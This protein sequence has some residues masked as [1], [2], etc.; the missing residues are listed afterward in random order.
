MR[1]YV[2]SVLVTAHDIA[3]D[4]WRAELAMVA[5][6]PEFKGHVTAQ[7]QHD[8]SAVADSLR[9]LTCRFCGLCGH[10]ASYCPIN[11]QMARKCASNKILHD[12]WATWRAARKSYIVLRSKMNQAQLQVDLAMKS[13]SI[14]SF[15]SSA[16]PLDG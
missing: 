3:I 1:N 6:T 11:A 8:L 10:E 9:D 15:S 12:Y 5:G 16:G 14:S 2:V 7:L 4:K 13:K